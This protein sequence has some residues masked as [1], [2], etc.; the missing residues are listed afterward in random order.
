MSKRR[1]KTRVRKSPPRRKAK[2]RGK[3]PFQ[4][5]GYHSV[6][7][8]LMVHDGVAAIGFYERAFGA[9]EKVRMDAPG[10]KI[11]HAELVIGDS[12]VMLADEAPG[13]GGRSPR[14]IGGTS[15]GLMVYVRDVDAF[16]ARAVAAG[17]RITRPIEDKFY[18]DR[19]G[20]IEDPFGHSWYFA[21]H[22]EEV[23]RAEMKKRMAKLF[24][25]G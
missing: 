9:R 22:T 6:T 8:Y 4:A 17:A 2:A 25:G 12:V 21:T 7:P 11:G 14:S 16:I 15:V 20:S 5:R 13:M 3:V 23:S 1:K 24:G 18:G 19:A 10:G